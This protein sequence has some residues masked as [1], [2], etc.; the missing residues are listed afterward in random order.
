MAKKPKEAKLYDENGFWVEERGRVKGALRRTFRL[1]PAPREIL[2]ASR[3]ELPPALKKDGTPGK[4]NQVRYRCAMC[5]DLFPQKWVQVDHIVPAVKLHRKES[6]LSY[7]EMVRGIFCG[8]ENLQVLCSTPKKFLPKNGESCHRKKT[9][10][11]NYIRDRWQEYLKG[12]SVQKNDILRLESEW[13]R[14]Y[15]QYLLDKKIKLEEKEKRKQNKKAPKTASKNGNSK[16][17]HQ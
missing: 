2:N 11:E 3:V 6:D 1:H 16:Q 12:S 17:T 4:K 10:E 5:L 8:K 7:D 9:N 14:D 15:E 13:R